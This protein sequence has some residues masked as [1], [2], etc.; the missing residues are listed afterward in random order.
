MR[1]V[2]ASSLGFM[3]TTETEDELLEVDCNGVLLPPER[4]E[5]QVPDTDDDEGQ[6]N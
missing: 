5:I 3:T 4:V 1:R 6:N 2:E